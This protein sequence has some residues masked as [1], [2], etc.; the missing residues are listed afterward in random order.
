MEVGTLLRRN[1]YFDSVVLM[2]LSSL[3]RR[4]EDGNLRWWNCY[5]CRGYST[6]FTER[7]CRPKDLWQRNFCFP[8]LFHKRRPV[9]IEESHDERASLTMGRG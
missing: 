7:A 6:S 4:L 9:A 5:D 8:R 1:T 3:L 2:E